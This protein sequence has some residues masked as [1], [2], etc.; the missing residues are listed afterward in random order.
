MP[1]LLPRAP[2]LEKTGNN[3]DAV[4]D[5][6]EAIRLNPLDARRLN[7]RG[8]LLHSMNERDKALADFTEAIRLDPGLTVAYL[9]RGSVLAEK[10]E[11]DKAVADLSAGIRLDPTSCSAYLSRCMTYL[12]ANRP[13]EAIADADAAIKIDADFARLLPAAGR[14]PCQPGWAR[15]GGQG[16]QRGDSARP[17]DRGGTRRPGGFVLCYGRL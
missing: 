13:G 14:G 9:N 17:D 2:A 8:N 15:R 1:T 5:F 11:Y 3:A 4:A 16:L 6:D 10:K 12:A 7:D